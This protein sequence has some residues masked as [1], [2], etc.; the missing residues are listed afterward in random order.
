MGQGQAVLVRFGMLRIILLSQ[1]GQAERAKELS[2]TI[3]REFNILPVV[4]TEREALQ[5]LATIGSR[6]RTGDS[7]ILF[8][9]A[10]LELPL[11]QTAEVIERATAFRGD[12]ATF[13][14][15]S[16][17]G[18][19]SS[20]EVA[21]HTLIQSFSPAQTWNSSVAI[22]K[23][24]LLQSIGQNTSI[25]QALLKSAIVAI[26]E[27]GEIDWSLATLEAPSNANLDNF[28]V[29]FSN[30]ENADF[31]QFAISTINIEELF[32]NHQWKQFE[33]ESAAACYHALAARFIALGA[34][35]QAKECLQYGDRLEDSPR[36]LALKGLIALK[37]GEV[38]AA[39]A[40]MVSSLQ[41]YEKRKG[42]G[43]T[44]Y[45]T[46]QP[47]NLEIINT[48]LQNG[49]SALNKH[50]ND[51][52]AGYFTDAVFQF[53]EFYKDCGLEQPPVQ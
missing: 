50:E 23:E 36:S 47:K 8:M 7:R 44:H 52:A 37:Q 22:V 35:E 24:S 2:K 41:E 20:P 5:E 17:E 33:E 29:K 4:L 9:D 25:A 3:S 43:S 1:E 14:I 40:N 45:L 30:E 42:E 26:G 38:L 18:A 49:L 27:H 28:D 13:T 34:F 39:V 31:I 12:F 10:H 21:S 15:Q 19:L 11:S 32:P 53:D 46:F 51:I 16:G 48:S 6:D